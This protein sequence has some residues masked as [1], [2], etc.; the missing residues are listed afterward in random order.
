[1]LF[2]RLEVC[3]NLLKMLLPTLRPSQSFR[4]SKPED[5]AQPAVDLGSICSARR[6]TRTT[7]ADMIEG[8][9]KKD[10]GVRAVAVNIER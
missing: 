2:A 9:R 5:V 3:D 7:E 4:P 8:S 6:G 10:D 1:M